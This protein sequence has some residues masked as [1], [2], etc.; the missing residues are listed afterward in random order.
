MTK[1]ERAAPGIPWSTAKTPLEAVCH[2]ILALA[3]AGKL[4]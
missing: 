2:L 1:V 4:S 3:E